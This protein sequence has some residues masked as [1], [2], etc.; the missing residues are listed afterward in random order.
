M[1]EG[2]HHILEDS[3]L[4]VH[5]GRPGSNLSIIY[6]SWLATSVSKSSYHQLHLCV[7]E[8]WNLFTSVTR[9]KDRWPKFQA[10]STQSRAKWIPLGHTCISL[11]AMVRGKRSKALHYK[12]NLEAHVHLGDALRT[13]W[14]WSH[15]AK[16]KFRNCYNKRQPLLWL[17]LDREGS[18][19][20]LLVIAERPDNHFVQRKVLITLHQK[21]MMCDALRIRTVWGVHI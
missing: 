6:W 3:H 20:V 21:G 4:Q 11:V 12:D 8:R 2:L 5:F 15:E 17:S 14:S 10:L 19:E 9:M 18:S 1:E 13:L 16:W 7:H